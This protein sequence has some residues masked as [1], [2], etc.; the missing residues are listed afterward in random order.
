MTAKRVKLARCSLAEFSSHLSWHAE[1]WPCT[2]W[3]LPV[4]RSAVRRIRGFQQFESICMTHTKHMMCF[5]WALDSGEEIISSTVT[6]FRE[7]IQKMIKSNLINSSLLIGL[8]EGTRLAPL[9]SV[10]V[11]VLA[12]AILTRVTR[13]WWLGL[14]FEFIRIHLLTQKS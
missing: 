2:G 6:L 1:R 8:I 9:S 3:S 7:L 10:Q 4:A 13:I 11:A 12:T 14:A 5:H